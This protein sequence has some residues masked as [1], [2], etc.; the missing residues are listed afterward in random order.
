MYQVVVKGFMS[1]LLGI[2]FL[3]GQIGMTVSTH[4]CG[5]RVAQRHLGLTP[6]HL[7]CGMES[8]LYAASKDDCES[9]KGLCCNND[10]QQVVGREYFDSSN[11]ELTFSPIQIFDQ[12]ILLPEYLEQVNSSFFNLLSYIPPLLDTDIPVLVQSFLC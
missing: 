7:G 8:D 12:E 5:G 2:I 6:T 11:H 4:Y 1:I 9:V 10:F 3:L